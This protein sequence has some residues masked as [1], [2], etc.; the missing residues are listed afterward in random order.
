MTEPNYEKPMKEIPLAPAALQACA[1][2]PWKKSNLDTMDAR[3]D[4]TV[5]DRH[6]ATDFWRDLAQNGATC[7][8]HL[9]TPGYYP[10]DETD[11]AEGFKRPHKF[12]GEAHRQCAG[13][14]AI[15][16]N[17]L[18][19]LDQYA[20]HAE[21]LEANPAGLTEPIAEHF[22]GILEDPG[23]APIPFRWPAQKVDDV[24]LDPAEFVDL[25]SN[26]WKRG[27]HW[28]ADMLNILQLTDP[29]LAACDC[30][31]CSQHEQIHPAEQVTLAGGS[32]VLIDKGIA[33]VVAAFN[34]AG[35]LTS[36]SCEALAPAM[37]EFDR[38]GFHTL[39][40]GPSGKVNYSRPLLEG[41][42][43][44]RFSSRTKAGKL[45]AMVLGK[46]YG[47]D[48]AGTV[49]QVTFPLEDAENVCLIVRTAAKKSAA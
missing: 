33:G 43:F 1:D 9:T 13:Q 23:S 22:R 37:Y 32:V 42:A 15:V 2:C 17:E 44:V 6:H 36:A 25:G 40:D 19:K 4:D 26:E 30:R 18:R 10:H 28:A 14:L 39:R 11:E 46:F 38:A 16:R 20:T 27:R 31:F 41:G 21:Y 7:R 8:C 47:V 35:I 34:D 5:F 3:R 49:A 48:Q 29:S 45:A 24:V 12:K